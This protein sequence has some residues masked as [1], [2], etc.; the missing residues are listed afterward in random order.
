[1]KNSATPAFF[2]ALK[3]ALSL[4]RKSWKTWAVLIV[5]L[6]LTAFVTCIIHLQVQNREKE[7]MKHIHH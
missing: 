7:K 1:M 4:P 2:Q 3:Y 5:G 6:V